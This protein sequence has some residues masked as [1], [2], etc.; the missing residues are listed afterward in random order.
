MLLFRY[1]TNYL[2]VV[3]A[4]V[5]AIVTV[6]VTSDVVGNTVTE[7]KMGDSHQ[8]GADSLWESGD[9]AHGS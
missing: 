3:S 4:I 1:K 5:A 6:S 9:K 7:A 8:P 2:D